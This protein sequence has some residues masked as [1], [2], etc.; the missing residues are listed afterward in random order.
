[1]LG[2]SGVNQA[3]G[4]KLEQAWREFQAGRIDQARTLLQRAIQ[5][6][7]STPELASVMSLVLMQSGASEQ[8][9][10]FA[11]RAVKARPDEPGFLVN[12]GN[13]L[14]QAGRREDSD[15][16]FQRAVALA[17]IVEGH[18][19]LANNRW[20]RR[21]YFAAGKHA[22][23][24][25]ELRPDDP[26][27]AATYA[28]MLNFCGRADLAAQICRRALAASQDPVLAAM[29][30]HAMNYVPGATPREIYE[31]HAAYG[32]ILSAR[33]PSR[34]GPWANERDPERRLRLGVL[35]HEFRQHAVASFLE[36]WLQHFDRGSI[37]LFC[38]SSVRT[39]DAVTARFRAYA[40]HWRDIARLGDA[41][42]YRRMIEDQIDVLVDTS[43]L[44][45]GHRLPILC[46]RAAPVQVT[47]LG[48][49]A[50]TGVGA[51]DYRI[52]DPV[53][54]PPGA[55]EFSVERLVRID[56]GFWCYRPMDGAPPPAPPPSDA[57]GHITFG[58]FN[59]MPKL[60]DPLI[61]LWARLLLSI[62]GSRLV[63]KA[64]ELN[65]EALRQ[66]VA[67]RFAA[68]GVDDHRVEVLGPTAGL[69]EHLGQYARVDVALDPFPYNGTTTTFDALFMGVPVV[70]MEGCV[71]AGRTG[72]SI[73]GTL[74]R[75]EWVGAD[76]AAYVSIAR[77][78]GADT[79]LRRRLRSSEDH[80]LRS[81]LLNSPLCDQPAYARR[82]DRTVRELWRGWCG[83]GAAS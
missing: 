30:A 61:G 27:M 36:P 60:N 33:Y 1:M 44:T 58:S 18:L 31:A 29:L 80:S 53:T 70:G 19:G 26:T 16:A 69:G 39:E 6:Y 13:A 42:A 79:D 23:R 22:A 21:E 4:S 32:R 62:P 7:P 17:P 77:A 34:P 28:T 65:E 66:E 74:G 24:A 68:A 10:Y 9:V 83:A 3:V 11:E 59:S 25:Y 12:Y 54:D 55:D 48:Y 57:A 73:L 45:Q 15:A 51:I 37:E 40:A 43:G 38:Y 41:D 20:D 78:L 2:E 8:A 46:T 75:R 63:L 71:H 82:M 50:T 47:Y 67:G 49:P 52:V 72:M 76:E 5:Q 64:L 14:A 81:Q 35:S 56:P